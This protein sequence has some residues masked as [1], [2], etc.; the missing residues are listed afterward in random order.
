MK[1]FK[2]FLSGAAALAFG[3]LSYVVYRDW[4]RSGLPFLDFI[5]QYPELDKQWKI[6]DAEEL[7]KSNG[8]YKEPTSSGDVKVNEE[9]EK[10]E[11]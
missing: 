7:L 6:E 4:K 2:G 9:D 3:E 1:Y 11:K 10:E 8:L 5:K